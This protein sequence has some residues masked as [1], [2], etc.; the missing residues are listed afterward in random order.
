MLFN[1]PRGFW[2]IAHTQISPGTVH[3]FRSA[4][5]EPGLDISFNKSPNWVIK[6]DERTCGTLMDTLQGNEHVTPRGGSEEEGCSLKVDPSVHGLQADIEVCDNE[7]IDVTEAEEG[8]GRP[9]DQ[10][11][12]S[13][14]SV[15]D[16]SK[17][18]GEKDLDN[19]SF[20][21]AN[22]REDFITEN[23]NL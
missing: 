4:T 20:S 21:Q 22:E 2:P 17:E 19:D 11:L 5:S 1:Q 23:G 6:P 8:Q 16:L 9:D 15:L 14:G 7:D 18:N 12:S 10:T 3:A 13:E